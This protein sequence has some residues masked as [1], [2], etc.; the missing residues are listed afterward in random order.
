VIVT[1]EATKDVSLFAEL[2]LSQKVTVLNQTPSAFYILQD[3]LVD[4]VNAV[5]IRYVIFGGEALN[6]SK[7]QP[8]KQLYNNCRLINMYG[9]TETTVHVTYQEIGWQHINGYSSI[10][11]KPIPT[12]S[13]Y[14]LDN[15]ENLIPVGVVGELY[16]GGAGLARGYLNRPDLTAE[17]FINDIFSSV[18]G[19]RLYKTGDLGRWLADGNMEY[20]GR[21]DDQV[22]IRGYRIELGEIERAQ[23]V[24][25]RG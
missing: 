14:I 24:S 25:P 15:N 10:I 7:L 19:S 16:I 6:P 3:V 12:L 13:A 20:L 17:K 22:K 1:R 18:E 2:L 11:G 4:K 9:I 5:P 23:Q 21:K 8:W